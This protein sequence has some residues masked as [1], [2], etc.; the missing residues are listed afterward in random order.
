[1][2]GGGNWSEADWFV[3][4]EIFKRM[5]S[6]FKP[7]I[8]LK[9]LTYLIQREEKDDK[10]I[11]LLVTIYKDCVVDWNE[12]NKATN[13]LDSHA[14]QIEK[15]ILK[16]LNTE[17]YILDIIEKV[18]AALNLWKFVFKVT[19]N[20]NAKQALHKNVVL[21]KTAEISTIITQVRPSIA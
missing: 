15:V 5:S 7:E 6:I 17:E 10:K 8:N 1:M 9:I 14:D 2:I 11:S 3:G 18:T 16:C 19:P 21:K 20:S 4:F 13:F 12:R